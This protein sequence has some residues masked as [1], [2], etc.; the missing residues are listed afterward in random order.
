MYAP[1]AATASSASERQGQQATGKPANGR[2]RTTG[3]ACA[4]GGCKGR[5]GRGTERRHWK[6]D[7]E[8]RQPETQR[9]V[10]T[11]T[12]RSFP[13]PGGSAC[14]YWNGYRSSAATRAIPVGHKLDRAPAR[15]LGDEEVGSE[16]PDEERRAHDQ[17]EQPPVVAREVLEEQLGC[18]RNGC[19]SS[20]RGALFEAA[21]PRVKGGE[22]RRGA[23][24]NR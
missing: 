23:R 21:E 5:G 6:G 4:V 20:T 11:E 24:P 13:K 18:G 9:K 10:E 19:L 22:K 16:G 2:D 8:S 7:R 14:C 12:E 1:A 3:G 17:R 15:G